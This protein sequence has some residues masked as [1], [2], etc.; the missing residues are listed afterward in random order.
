MSSF[1]QDTLNKTVIM[2]S[3]TTYET[4]INHNHNLNEEK[5]ILTVKLIALFG[6]IFVTIL[7]GFLP[8]MW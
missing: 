1:F 3:S 8:L 5:F 4:S 7:F 2:N 6:I